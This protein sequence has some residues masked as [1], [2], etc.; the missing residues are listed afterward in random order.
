MN[1]I[2]ACLTLCT[3]SLT[4]QER[5]EDI[6]KRFLK[7]M[8]FEQT[9][10]ESGDV[11]FNMVK[12]SLE[13]H[14][15]SDKAMAEVKDAFLAYMTRLA[16][17]PELRDVTIKTYQKHFTDQELEELINFF[18]TPLGKKIQKKQPQIMGS[19]MELSMKIAKRH[20]PAYQDALQEI[21]QR[22]EAE[23]LK[24]EEAEE[25]RS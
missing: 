13:K 17:D 11:G 9:V 24:K 18:D 3:L 2:L 10:I 14:N 7:A 1:L 20:V 19:V 8:D 15:L 22:H 23:K 4:A 6:A 25:R 16:T 21:L 12:Q 5:N